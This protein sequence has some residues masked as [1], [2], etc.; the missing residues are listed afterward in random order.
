MVAK[1]LAIAFLLEK[2]YEYRSIQKLLR[3][4][5]GTITAVNLSRNLGSEGYKKV[6]AK[7]IKKENLV[8]LFDKTLIKLL[9]I[10]S[11][12]GKGKSA[13]IYLKDR[14]ENQKKKKK[15][16]NIAS[17]IRIIEVVK[18]IVQL[19]SLRPRNSRGR[20]GRRRGDRQVNI[21]ENQYKLQYA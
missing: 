20:R 2:K 3:V 13:W 14:A 12:L 1:R 9:T 4:S 21:F 11:S 5:T 7:I 6:V 15:F 8:D 18:N 10:P 19:I 17:M 16:F